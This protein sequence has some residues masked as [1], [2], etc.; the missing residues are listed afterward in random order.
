MRP[1]SP[2]SNPLAAALQALDP[3]GT[4]GFEG[5]IARM[6]SYLTG[7]SF[8]PARSGPQR[9]RDLDSDTASPWFAV[10]ECKR[11]RGDT[12]LDQ[13]ELIAEIHIA[14]SEDPQIDVWILATSRDVDANVARWLQEMSRERGIDYLILECGSAGDPGDLDVLCAN[15]SAL[16]LQHCAPVLPNGTSELETH[17]TAVRSS[18][19]FSARLQRISNSLDGGTVGLPT[20]RDRLNEKLGQA[21][22]S[23]DASVGRF[24]R[25]LDVAGVGDVRDIPRLGVRARLDAFIDAS[26][27]PVSSTLCVVH[28][29][30]GNGK[31]WAVASWVHARIGRENAPAVFWFSAG[32]CTSESPI[33]QLADHAT[34]ALASGREINFF[35]KLQRWTEGATTRQQLLVVL[36]GIN[37]RQAITFWA[38]HLVRSI[39]EFKGHV[40]IIVTCRTQTWRDELAE[41]LLLRPHLIE[42][43]PFDDNEFAEAL[44][45][46]DLADV[47]RLRRVGPLVR[48]PRYLATALK[49]VQQLQAGEDLT[50]ERLFYDAMRARVRTRTD[51]PLGGRDFEVLLRDL[52]RRASESVRSQDVVAS[53]PG[54]ESHG[55]ILRE[56]ASG[57]VLRACPSGGYSVEESYLVEG[58][59]L[60][61]VDVLRNNTGSIE[62]LRQRVADWLSDTHR[63][64]LTARICASAS[65]RALMDPTVPREAPAALVLEFINCTNPDAGLLDGVLMLAARQVNVLC[66]VCERLWV[67]PG[68]DHAVEREVLKGLVA[69]ASDT[70]RQ[71]AI[72]TRLIRWAGFIHPLGEHE[73]DLSR[74]RAPALDA[75]AV[76]LVPLVDQ[77]T[78]VGG[79]ISLTR[80]EDQRLVRL[81][82]LAL[83]VVSFCD[84]RFFYPMLVTSLA[85]DAVMASSRST[86]VY[87]IIASSRQPLADLVQATLGT[88]TGL[89]STE[90]VRVE[91]RLVRALAAPNLAGQ[92]RALDAQA[93][94][95]Q[96]DDRYAR[97]FRTPTSQDLPQYLVDPEV[98]SH[99]RLAKAKV[100]ASDPDVSFPPAFVHQVQ[101]AVSSF[102]ARSRRQGL[103]TAEA[104][105]SWDLFEPILCRVDPDLLLTKIL[106]FVSDISER[107]GERLY[108]WVFSADSLTSLLGSTEVITL[109]QAWEVLITRATEED[110]PGRVAE[111]M[112]LCM[113]LSHAAPS[114]QVDMLISRPEDARLLA[115]ASTRFRSLDSLEEQRSIAARID[116]SNHALTAVLWFASKQSGLNDEVWLEPVRRGLASAST[117][118]R[119]LALQIAANLSPQ[120]QSQLVDVLTV[121][122]PQSC[123]LEKLYGTRLLLDH[124]KGPILSVLSRCSLRECCHLAGRPNTHRRAEVLQAF[125]GLVL[126]WLRRRI[127]PASATP[128][129]LPITVGDPQTSD[130]PWAGV[131]VDWSEQDNSVSFRSEMSIWGGL[132]PGNQDEFARVL[133]GSDERSAELQAALLSALETAQQEGDWGFA[134]F[135]SD[136]TLTGLVEADATFLPEIE[137]LLREA[138][139]R[140]TLYAALPFATALCRSLLPSRLSDALRLRSVIGYERSLVTDVDGWTGEKLFNVALCS[141]SESDETRK[142]WLQQLDDAKNDAELLLFAEQLVAGGNGPWLQALAQRELQSDAT[143]YRRRAVLL[144]AASAPDDSSFESSIEHNGAEACGL[145]DVVAS[146][147]QYRDTARRMSHWIDKGVKADSALPAY[148]AYRLLVSCVDRRV[149]RL[150]SKACKDAEGAC[151]TP[152]F[153]R[154]FSRDDLKNAVKRHESKDRKTLLGVKVSEHDAAPWIDL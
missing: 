6:L 124:A 89:S 128:T 77:A 70:D 135:W 3:T 125:A 123:A 9:G 51:Y 19:S 111:A 33:R 90:A 113:L 63:F 13:R 83:A 41:R 133:R 20:F 152:I 73:R 54:T 102:N 131:S 68:V 96:V 95:T 31:S 110:E 154:M 99:L 78:D 122:S 43:K 2:T 119:G 93:P 88:L 108:A 94:P 112:L 39:D 11:Y 132:P 115:R 139:A 46:M 87:W 8:R 150:L 136:D 106:E 65:I 49:I 74:D 144:L 117:V 26:L 56:L 5:L 129:S 60:L 76:A 140:Q 64:P 147:R 86:V 27:E 114:E 121:R 97:V 35:A 47:E 116:E 66:D 10:V 80:V 91:R 61:L 67:R 138:V 148:C 16:V 84:R 104:D 14:T 101:A 57:G 42:V 120:V 28:G 146:A 25:R 58:M 103:S 36:D 1:A 134:S 17:L 7:V 82:R 40:S 52:A 38:R 126:D 71:E 34:E 130:H 29:E 127:R 62:Q 153:F 22:R 45:E 53:L 15:A 92:L 100:A 59:A 107:S 79:G 105:D 81:G 137:A 142:W 109:R 145:D 23:E 4:N 72:R 85:A 141:A 30:E 24:E 12:K 44:I 37:E 98:P 151:R 75:R 21:M 143:Y 18:A 149:W 69:A 118:D 50:V 32:D 48:K 55:D